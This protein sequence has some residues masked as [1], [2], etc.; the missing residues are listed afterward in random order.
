MKNTPLAFALLFSFTSVTATLAQSAPEETV[1]QTVQQPEVAQHI[2]FLASDELR[3]RDTGSPELE[4]AARYLAEQF[5]SYGLD[6]VLGAEGYFQPVDLVSAK[7]PAQATLT[8][9]KETFRIASDLLVLSGDSVALEAP[10]VFANYG[11]AEDLDAVDVEGK[12]VV[13]KA[14]SEGVNNPQ[15]FYYMSP[16][17]R[18]RVAARGGLALVELYRSNQVP[19]TLLVQY[20]NAEQLSLGSDDEDTPSNLPL[21]WL[22]DPKGKRLTLFQDADKQL[23]TLTIAN[24]EDTP[25]PAKNVVA[26]IEGTDPN[27]NDEYLVLSAHYDHIGTGS[28]PDPNDSIYNGARDNAIG[29]TSL[30]SAAKYFG[31]HP[32]KRSVLFVAL[33]AEEK[34]LLGSAWYAAHPLVPLDQTIFNLNTDG[35]GYNDTTKVTAIGLERT[36][37]REAIV[38]ASQAF[39]LEAIVDPVPEQNLYDR[40]DNVSFAQKGI[41]AV[42]FAPG[43]T[44]FDAEVMKNYHQVS[45]EVATLNFNY[46]ERYCEAYTLAAQRIANM[47]EKPFWKEG[48]KYETAG[49]ELYGE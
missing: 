5:R 31:E 23:A 13:T 9:G 21:L 11:T 48:D 47:P 20:L 12:I 43:L 22:N 46:V 19:W 39:G 37:A 26:T 35:A 15:S 2:R 34:G 49:K 32:P 38:S 29:V 45:D 30:L 17:K 7:P 16:E 3:G 28:S 18:D 25:V 6:T 36:T 40:S 44:A 14:G 24:K 4:I 33:T 1:A 41:P 42:N 10:V 27:L 8:Y